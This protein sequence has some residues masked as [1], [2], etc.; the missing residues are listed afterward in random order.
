VYVNGLPQKND[1]EKIKQNIEK[2]VN[3]IP[4]HS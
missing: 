3:T 4:K 2:L 1:V